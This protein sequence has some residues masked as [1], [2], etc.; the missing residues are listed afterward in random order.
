M[1]RHHK[2]TDLL[3][4][5][6]LARSTFYY[7]I[8]ATQR[9]D[10]Q[11]TMEAKI[12]VVYDEHKGRY[13]YRRITAVLRSST[14][15]PVNHKCV[16]RLMKKMGLR[17]LIRARRRSRHIPGMSDEHVPNVLQRDFC[18]AAPN[19]KWSTDVTEFNVNGRK[20]YLSACMDRYNGEIVA[21]RMA[22]RPVFELVSGTLEAALS[23]I[24]S[25]SEL[26]VH[27]D[28]GWHYKMQPYRA[29]L[30]RSG[31]KQSMSRKGNCFDNAAIESFFRHAEGR[32]FP[33]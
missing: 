25:A 28:Q 2:L 15:E 11:S 32:V 12:R 29:M 3:R 30:A 22:T 23:R 13:G 4:V 14:E 18:A 21:Y 7:Q 5:A 33:P 9:A 27:S 6:G 1:R 19:Q 24:G 8:Q 16:Q 31:V 17:A 10:Q 26:I 20:L